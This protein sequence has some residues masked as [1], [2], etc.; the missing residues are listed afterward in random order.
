MT[1]TSTVTTTSTVAD[2]KLG[3]VG[4]P[5]PGAEVKIADDGEILIRGPHI[6]RGYYGTGDT[7]AFG[8][9]ADGWL[10][11]G[12]LG[13]ARRGRLPHDHRPQEGHHDHRGRQEPHAREHGERPQALA[14][15]LPGRH[16]R[17][18]PALPG[19]ADHARPGGDRPLRARARPPRGPRLAARASPKIV[20]LIQ[21]ELDRV[22]E[23]YARVEQVKRF[24]ILD[25]DLSQE[26]GELTPTL[27][28][29]R[30]VVNELYAEQFEALYSN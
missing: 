6:F 27:K 1:E 20:E 28:V 2:H 19:R 3:T 22:N 10:H 5:I 13:V 17:R 4:R 29:K 24:F 14:L 16:A 26:T 25:H 12:D 30:N 7:T 11:T 15:D 21:G 18:P 23:N 9:V 8:A